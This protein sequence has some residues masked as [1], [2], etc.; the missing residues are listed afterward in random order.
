MKRKKLTR[1]EKKELAKKGIC[2]KC[3]QK[4]LKFKGDVILCENCGFKVVK[5]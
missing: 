1:K 5:Y 3:G 2:W 4:T